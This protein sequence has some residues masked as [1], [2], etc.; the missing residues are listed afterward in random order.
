MV[1][2]NEE[3][4]IINPEDIDPTIGRFRN[5]IQ[6]VVIQPSTKRQRIENFSIPSSPSLDPTKPHSSQPY[7]SMSLY[8]GLTEPM[9]EKHPNAGSGDAL[10]VSAAFGSKFLVLPNP[11][12]E[13][14]SEIIA[15][16]TSTN[17][18]Y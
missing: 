6:S 13:V 14:S 3:E 8:Q 17:G 16:S 1:T 2:F 7:V 5:L 12:P 11:A 15:S 18:N 10:N 9:H 4:I